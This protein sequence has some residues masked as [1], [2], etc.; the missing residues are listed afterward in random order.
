MEVGSITKIAKTAFWYALNSLTSPRATFLLGEPFFWVRGMRRKRRR[1][2]LS[3]IKRVL[4][5]RLDE[6]GDLVLTIPFLRELRRNLPDASITLIVKPSVYNLMELCSYVDQV[7][8]YEWSVAGKYPAVERHCRAL[9]LS[10]RHLWCRRFD[11]AIIPR[12]DA[13]SYHATFVAYLSGASWRVGYSENATPHKQLLNG[14]FDRLFTHILKD[15]TLKHEVEHNLDVIPFL[16]GTVRDDRLELWLSPED[17]AF[18][19]ELLKSHG[20][21]R[22]TL[23]IAFGPGKR[24]PKRRWPLSSFVQLGSWLK[25]KYHARIMIVGETG[26]KA[27]AEELQRQLGDIVINMVG[28][29]TLREAFA[30]FRHCDL[31]V[32]ND[33]GPKHMA[34]AAGVPVIEI[35]G[36]P[37][38]G[39]PFHTY[40]PT[41]FGPWGVTHLVLQPETALEPCS[42]TCTA[43]EPHCILGITVE[44]VENAVMTL[45]RQDSLSISQRR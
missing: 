14:G 44:Q 7:L 8:T 18:G 13:D 21:S 9:Q 33:Y 36:H 45:L 34:A 37:L 42:D 12:F 3:E 30:L 31:Y 24:D 16:G 41:R 11:L 5:V 39:S 25:R 40:S 20:I 38:L 23:L 19:D 43:V 29:T 26:E 32:G 1:I 35:N 6:M 22:D 2:E 17:A 4:V 27:L 10:H 15:N 28:Q